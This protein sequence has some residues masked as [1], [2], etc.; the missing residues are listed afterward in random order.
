MSS[1]PV[2]VAPSQ[3]EAATE[4]RTY[5]HITKG[6]ND[7][8]SEDSDRL[9]PHPNSPN[10]AVHLGDLLWTPFS[11]MCMLK[12]GSKKQWPAENNCLHRLTTYKD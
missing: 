3:Q 2:L 6:W 11:G 8:F 7:R 10:V 5:P 4:E 12:L 9:P 1:H